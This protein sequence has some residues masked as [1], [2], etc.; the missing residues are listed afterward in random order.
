M[1]KFSVALYH[2]ENKITD[3]HFDRANILLVRLC[4]SEVEARD[5]KFA[6]IQAWIDNVGR[7][8][9]EFLDRVEAPQFVREAESNPDVIAKTVI[10]L[11]FG[12]YIDGRYG[13]TYLLHNGVEG[14][15]MCVCEAE[16]E[17]VA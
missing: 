6:A 15:L 1:K 4:S 16:V 11:P 9:R 14:W 17:E 2:C 5:E 13:G 3:I 7:Y 10:S 12:G 8:R